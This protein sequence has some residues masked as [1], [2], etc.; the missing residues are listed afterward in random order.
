MALV[1]EKKANR[2]DPELYESDYSLWLFENARLLREGRFAEADM[3]N[4][5]EE[6]ED[7]G[8]SEYRALGSHI[9]VLLL[10]LL[11]WQFQPGHRSA[12]WR[13]SIFN[14]RDSIDRLLR[15]SPSLRKHIP[16]L[17]RDRYPAARYN[18]ANETDLPEATFPLAC[19]Y[20]PE[21][22]LDADSWPNP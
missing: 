9:G 18:A 12:S 8:R 5:A 14:A 19:P 3:T 21:Q 10:H 17:A 11:K 13:G 6:L 1:H 15:E 7:M 20:D 2:A 16:N 22:L 4:I